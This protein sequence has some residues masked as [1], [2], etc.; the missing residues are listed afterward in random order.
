MPSYIVTLNC[1]FYCCPISQKKSRTHPGAVPAQQQDA[2]EERGAIGDD[3]H[4]DNIPRTIVARSYKVAPCVG[5]LIKDVRKMMG[6][7]TASN[8]RERSYNRMK[9]YASV[10]SQLG[11]SHMLSFSQTKN[12]N[13]V[14]RVARFHQGPTLHFRVPAYSLTKHVRGLQRRPYDSAA[15]FN[16]PPLVFAL[17][18]ILTRTHASLTLHHVY[19]GGAEQFRAVRRPGKPLETAA[20]DP[21]EPISLH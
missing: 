9:D 14:L 6:P 18:C 5:E 19:I 16:T 15:A 10:A 11:I 3:V 2:S 17:L 8:L 7:Y 20:S 21:A 4:A 12:K 1:C 13:I